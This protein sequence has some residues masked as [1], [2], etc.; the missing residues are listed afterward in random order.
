MQEA[1]KYAAPA[2]ERHED[3]KGLLLV[4]NGSYCPPGTDN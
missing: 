3:V 2:I 1:S 4:Q